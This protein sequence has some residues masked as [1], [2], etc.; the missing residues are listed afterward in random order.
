MRISEIY[1]S[2]QGEGPRVGLPTIF[3]RFAG[4]N[5]SCPG[6]PCD[7]QHAI[8]PKLYRSEWQERGPEQVFDM[9]ME[10]VVKTGARN[11]CFTGGE[12]FL[13]RN[14]DLRQLVSRLHSQRLHME[15]F[16]NGTLEWPD[17]AIYSFNGL[18]M[19]WKL[20]GSGEKI[21]PLG[22]MMKNASR[23]SSKDAIKFTVKDREDITEAYAA[24]NMLSQIT[25]AQVFCGPVWGSG[26]ITPG[27]VADWI[28]EHRLPWRLNIQ[29]HKYIWP[30]DA[31][32]T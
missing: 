11:V 19:D 6:W 22:T 25:N 8:D 14:E 9:V 32:R 4:C 15:A 23:L 10:Q 21:D 18:V 12:P 31:R 29:V 26:N 24:W 3:L 7:T 13:Q 5:L 1:T 20:S 2:M 16:T 17:W 27:G 28:L 30:P